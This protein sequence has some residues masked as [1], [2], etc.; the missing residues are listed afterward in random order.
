MDNAENETVL[1]MVQPNMKIF[2][3]S[4]L[5]AKFRTLKSVLLLCL[6]QK[7]SVLLEDAWDLGSELK[8]NHKLSSRD[9][10]W[11]LGFNGS[12]GLSVF[13]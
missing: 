11:F 9:L 8:R 12:L 2:N 10:L 4:F 6:K 5:G 13:F 7:K 1:L 3:E